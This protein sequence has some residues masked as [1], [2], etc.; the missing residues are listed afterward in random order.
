MAELHPFNGIRYNPQKVEN[1]SQVICPPYDIINP[2]QQEELYLRNQYNYVRVEYGK[3][4]PGDTSSDDKYS[5]A[6]AFLEQWLEDEILVRDKAKTIYI[7]DHYFIYQ[8]QIWKRRGIVAC[9]RLE[10]WHRMVVRPHEE[11][12]GEPK[13]DRI[14]L[15]RAIKANTSPILA[16]YSDEQQR[17]AAA[18]EQATITMPHMRMGTLDGEWHNVWAIT[19]PAIQREIIASFESE[20]LYIADGHHRYESALVYQREQI[21]L[22]QGYFPGEAFNFVMMTL[23]SFADPGLLLLPTHRVLRGLAP[24]K[25]E[26]LKSTLDSFFEMQEISFNG[27]DDWSK[28]DAWQIA[29]KRPH[30]ALYGLSNEKMLLLA[31]RDYEEAGSFMPS[32]HSDV[33]KQMDVSLVEH[34]ILEKLLQIQPETEDGLAFDHDRSSAVQS[35]RAGDFQ[36]AFILQPLQ[37]AV[38]KEISDLADRMPRKSTYFHPKLPSGLVTNRLV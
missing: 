1:L 20:P 29:E 28:V 32:F 27:A 4:N 35:V 16:M 11:I 7:D 18:L 9:V 13:T 2:K 15:I 21:A 22:N 8:K 3:Q 31:L 12:M 5:R 19:A 30:I 33:Y 36:L 24:T 38:I 23:V 37:P 25:L 10:E 14:N 26:S 17:I 6:T 34:L